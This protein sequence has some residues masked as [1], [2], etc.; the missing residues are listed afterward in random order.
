MKPD[1]LAKRRDRVARIQ[2]KRP[3]QPP[4]DITVVMELDPSDDPELLRKFDHWLQKV[5]LAHGASGEGR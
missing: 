4:E 1:G 3:R 2:A 5:L